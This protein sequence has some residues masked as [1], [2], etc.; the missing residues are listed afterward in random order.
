MKR[1]C[2]AYEKFAPSP[3]GTNLHF[4]GSRPQ[5]TLPDVVETLSKKFQ[6]PGVAVGVFADGQRSMPV[7]A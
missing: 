2:M 6:I 5:V 4:L 7:T 1:L 3:I